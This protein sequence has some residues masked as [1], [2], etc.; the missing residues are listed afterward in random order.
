[1]LS[2]Q[3]KLSSETPGESW[4]VEIGIGD[5]PDDTEGFKSGIRREAGSLFCLLSLLLNDPAIG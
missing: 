3:G 2:V 1:M 5:L 4:A